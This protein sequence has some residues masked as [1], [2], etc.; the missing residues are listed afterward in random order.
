M[1]YLQIKITL[2]V[3]DTKLTKVDKR[4]KIGKSHKGSIKR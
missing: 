1:V 3:N 2:S 4:G